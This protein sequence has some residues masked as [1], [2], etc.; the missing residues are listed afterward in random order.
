MLDSRYLYL[1]QA[2]GLG[3][4]WL[5]QTAQVLPAHSTATRQTSKAQ[6]TQQPITAPRA[7]AV[8]TM[9]T[10]AA[11]VASPIAATPA[12]QSIP[13]PPVESVATTLA[14]IDSFSLDSL[15]VILHSCH[16]CN[17]VQE[18]THPISGH[19]SSQ[20]R[21]MVVSINPSPEDDSRQQLFSGQSG[22]LLRNMLLALN[23]TDEA[24]F[25]TSQIKCAPN[26]NLTIKHEQQQACMPYLSQQI[27]LLQPQAILLLGQQFHK[28][29]QTQLAASLQ[30]RP[31]VI[32]HHPARLLSQSHLKAQVWQSLQKLYQYL[33]K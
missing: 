30:G 4:M 2:L 15:S 7:V 22:V 32:T 26:L 1:H 8:T 23:L 33:I 19:G 16:R 10:E 18:R 27:R 28:M 25:Y 9:T 6:L 21:L 11:S 5:S 17:L 14:P 3:P 31:Y 12:I 24:V 13:V 20:P 29:D